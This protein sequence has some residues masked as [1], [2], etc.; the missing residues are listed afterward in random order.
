M[1]QALFGGA[2]GLIVGLA[3]F[4]ALERLVTL[5]MAGAQPRRV[6]GWQ[7]LR[8]ALTVLCFVGIAQLGGVAL[9]AALGGYIVARVLRTHGIAR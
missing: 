5:G 8:L 1:P 2:A 7:A 9:V 6:I 3:S 4:K